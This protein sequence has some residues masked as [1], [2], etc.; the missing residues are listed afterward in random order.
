MTLRQRVI[1]AID[2]NEPDVCPWQI[3]LTEPAHDKLAEHYGTA[4]VEPMLGN[5]IARVSIR[6]LMDW[7]DVGAG[8]FRDEFGVVW[9][10]TVDKDIGVPENRVLDKPTLAGLSLPDP[11]C[12]MRVRQ[13]EKA[14]AGAG[15]KFRMLSMGFSLFERAWTLRG[16]ENFYI[17]MVTNESFV[18]DLLDV[19]CDWCVSVIRSMPMQLVDG[20]QFGD[21]WGGQNGLLMGKALWDRFIK[22][23]ITRMYAAAREAGAYVM[24]HSCGKVQELFD[25]LIEAGL[26]MFNPFQPE[27]MDVCEISRRYKGRLAF[28]GGLSIQKT[29]PFGTPD[30][31]RAEVRRLI[32]EVG[33]GGGYVLSPSHDVPGDV[34][35]ENLLALIDEVKAQ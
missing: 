29:L 32:E 16:L 22:P 19:L 23:R 26:N 31:V 18:D 17:D 11:A 30:E 6:R 10:R 35:L 8:H 15:E 1:A 4:D 7:T 34:P 27:V 28:L 24:I 14:L 9:N 20:V 13:V 21:D 25:D 3:Y 5:H 33:A 12:E 2:F